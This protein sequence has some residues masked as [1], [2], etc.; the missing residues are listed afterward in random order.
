MLGIVAV[1][2][3]QANGVEHAQREV[4]LIHSFGDLFLRVRHEYS[5]L[6]RSSSSSAVHTPTYLG[7]RVDLL[8]HWY[9]NAGRVER[10]GG[11]SLGGVDVDILVEECD[12]PF[13]IV[14][15][16]PCL[17]PTKLRLRSILGLPPPGP[18]PAAA[19]GASSPSTS[20]A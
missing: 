9:L 15:F 13:R 18:S 4:A 6:L 8:E 10:N 1:E 16:S 3:C 7:Y 14:S 20:S 11:R 2:V 19:V 12:A 17:N 5:E